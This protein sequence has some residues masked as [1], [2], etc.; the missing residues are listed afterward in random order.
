MN[1]DLG[2]RVLGLHKLKIFKIIFPLSN[3]MTSFLENLKLHSLVA[4]LNTTVKD[5]LIHTIY[6]LILFRYPAINFDF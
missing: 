1:F 5:S 4:N 6:N 2:F 3:L